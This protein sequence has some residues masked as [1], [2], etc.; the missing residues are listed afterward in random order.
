ML[1]TELNEGELTFDQVTFVEQKEVC[2][3]NDIANF[4]NS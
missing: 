3:I 1:K 2:Q 4:Q